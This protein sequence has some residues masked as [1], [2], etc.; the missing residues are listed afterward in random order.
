MGGPTSTRSDIVTVEREGEIAHV[1]LDRP[2]KLNSLT[3]DTLAA[4]KL[5]AEGLAADRTVRG[6]LLSGEGRSFCAGLDFATVGADPDGIARAFAADP[7]TGANLFQEACWAWRRVP[8]PVV[9]AVHGHCL[10]GG[11]QLALA[12]DFRFTTPDAEWSA[13]EI[14]WGLIPDMSGIQSLSQQVGL[15]VAKRLAMTGEL[16]SGT[17]AHALG[18]ATEVTDDPQAAGM[19]LLRQIATRSPDAVAA[20][21]RVFQDTW[22]SPDAVVFER[23]RVEQEPL[24]TAANT[25][26]AHRRAAGEQVEYRVRR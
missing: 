8:V 26:I 3:L 25:A 24:L 23:E 16:I 17:Q 7:E 1:R 18:L 20:V 2:D 5:T 10:G 4:L 19:A 12:A 6:I 15:D 21:K 9:A 13:L 14:K 22:W 11:L